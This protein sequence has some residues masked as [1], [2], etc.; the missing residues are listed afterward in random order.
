MNVTEELMYS[1]STALCEW[2]LCVE[3][4]VKIYY[5]L[6]CNFGWADFAMLSQI[7]KYIHMGTVIILLRYFHVYRYT[8]FR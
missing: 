1:E 6:L 2:K 7:A 5:M 8:A 4:I 3:V